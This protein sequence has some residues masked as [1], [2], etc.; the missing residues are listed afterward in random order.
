MSDKT[1]AL[2]FETFADK[3]TAKIRIPR[4]EGYAPAV[5]AIGVHSTII[6]KQ[7]AQIVIETSEGEITERV[8]TFRAKIEFTLS[9]TDD[10]TDYYIGIYGNKAPCRLSSVGITYARLP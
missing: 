9:D 10:E 7:N 6:N 1:R 4:V 3:D 5:V 2:C 8:N